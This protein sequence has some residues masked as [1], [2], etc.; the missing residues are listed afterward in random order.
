MRHDPES[1]HRPDPDEEPE[2]LQ[3]EIEAPVERG[4]DF[5]ASTARPDL[6]GEAAEA[7]V[8]DQAAVAWEGEE[9]DEAE[10]G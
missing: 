9:G 1:W 8:L 10:L 6:E 3:E 7:D 4:E 2:T 5:K